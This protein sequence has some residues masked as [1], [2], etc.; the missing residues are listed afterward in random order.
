[1]VRSEMVTFAEAS[2]SNT[3]TWLPPLM[4]ITLPPSMV[5]LALMVFVLVTRNRRRAAAVETH[6]AVE[7]PAAREAG[8]KGRLGATRTAAVADN[9]PEDAGARVSV[10]SRNVVATTI[11]RGIGWFL[12][13]GRESSHGGRGPVNQ[14]RATREQAWR[15]EG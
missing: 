5:V 1:M 13:A 10:A 3:R 8:Y 4:V 6:S 11:G 2:I 15:L 12:L 14:K 9:T 7:T